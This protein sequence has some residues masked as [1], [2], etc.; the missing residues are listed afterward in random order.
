MLQSFKYVLTYLTNFGTIHHQG[1][2]RGLK[3]AR[4]SPLGKGAGTGGKVRERKMKRTW[5]LLLLDI[6]L[7]STIP[8]RM[9]SYHREDSILWA[10]CG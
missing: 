10:N 2:M 4:R 6:L 3:M 7:I 5:R 8:G 1:S 9:I